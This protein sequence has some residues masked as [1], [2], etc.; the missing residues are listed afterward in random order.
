MSLWQKVE[1]ETL[2]LQEKLDGTCHLDSIL[3][4]KPP[5]PKNNPSGWT[6]FIGLKRIR[7]VILRTQKCLFHWK[8]GKED[9][10][11]GNWTFLVFA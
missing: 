11:K 5:S 3:Y 9:F 6:R 7:W 8:L 1:S 4:S 10:S 2:P